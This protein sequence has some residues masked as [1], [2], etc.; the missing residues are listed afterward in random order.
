MKIMSL[1]KIIRKFLLKERIKIDLRITQFLPKLIIENRNLF[2]WNLLILFSSGTFWSW[3]GNKQEK[4]FSHNLYILKRPNCP[5]NAIW[6]I[7][8]W[9]AL[10]RV[11]LSPSSTIGRSPMP[12]NINSSRRIIY[13]KKGQDL[14]V[15]LDFTCSCRVFMINCISV[16]VV[17]SKS[18]LST[19]SI[20]LFSLSEIQY[21]WIDRIFSKLRK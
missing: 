12:S 11:I 2:A 19:T 17:S 3:S 9:F 20:S 8:G 13:T 5:S 1:F 7:T 21:S 16:F 10:C 4:N 6:S 14:D 15:R 18:S